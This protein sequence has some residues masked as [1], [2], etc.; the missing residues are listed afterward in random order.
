VLWEA[1][2]IGIFSN[3]TIWKL[4][5]DE[6][7]GHADMLNTGILHTLWDMRNLVCT[8]LNLSRCVCSVLLVE[9]GWGAE[10]A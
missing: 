4:N 5:T 10:K 1:M 8:C 7:A 9:T 2:L 6:T 3:D